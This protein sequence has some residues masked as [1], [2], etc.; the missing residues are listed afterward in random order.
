MKNPEFALSQSTKVIV[1]AIPDRSGVYLQCRAVYTAGTLQH[2]Q[3]TCSVG[4]YTEDTLLLHF[5]Y[6]ASG[7]VH[8]KYTADWPLM[9]AYLYTAH[10]LP[11]SG[12][13][14]A[15]YTGFILPVHST[16]VWDINHMASSFISG[17][18]MGVFE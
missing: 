13:V 8:S 7:S 14:C 2:K 4:K 16:S 11:A 17:N 9:A 3:C 1:F 10:T 5:G 6:T 18:V 15:A 12:S